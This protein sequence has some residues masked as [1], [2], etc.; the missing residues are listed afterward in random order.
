MTLF[1]KKSSTYS[2]GVQ[3]ALPAHLRSKCSDFH[4]RQRGEFFA[5]FSRSRAHAGWQPA[6]PANK[7]CFFFYVKIDSAISTVDS[8]FLNNP[9]STNS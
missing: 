6:L 5:L 4:Q 8:H 3:A 9:R 1:F 2:L 7:L